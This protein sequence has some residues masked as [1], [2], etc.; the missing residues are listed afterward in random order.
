MID[1]KKF[2]IID[3]TVIKAQQYQAKVQTAQ[4]LITVEGLILARIIGPHVATGA[5]ELCIDLYQSNDDSNKSL[6][7][8]WNQGRIAPTRRGF[9]KGVIA[10]VCVCC[11][12][13]FTAR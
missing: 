12:Q 5:F 2:E 13:V 9:E 4:K 8:F 11:C 7:A 10:R 6:F 3:K 1:T